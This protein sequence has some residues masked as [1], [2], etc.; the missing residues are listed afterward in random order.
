MKIH[1]CY[2]VYQY[3]IPLPSNISF[4]EYTLIY[5]TMICEYAMILIICLEVVGH[6][7]SFC[8]EAIMNKATINIH[9]WVFMWTCISIS[10]GYIP[11]IRIARSYSNSR[12]NLL[13]NCTLLCKVTRHIVFP[14]TVY[15]GSNFF[16]FLEMF[17][18]V[19]YYSSHSVWDEEVS[20]CGFELHL[21][22]G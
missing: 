7:G 8:L 18:T 17:V 13:K 12:F 4:Y 15:K 3:F 19:F 11:R 20:H 5:Y 6:L 10:L 22:D 1:P 16:T 21:P 14:L 9:V 2:S